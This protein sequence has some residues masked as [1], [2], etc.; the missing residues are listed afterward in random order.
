MAST[1]SE[2]RSGVTGVFNLMLA[3][4]ASGL[5]VLIFYIFDRNFMSPLAVSI[6]WIALP[7]LLI[8]LSI[9]VNIINQSI[10]C[11]GKTDLLSH[12]KISWVTLAIVYSVLFL[13][14]VSYVRAP[15]TSLFAGFFPQN[16][17][18]SVVGLEARLPIVRGI[19]IGYYMLFGI[20]L[21]QII[22]SGYGTICK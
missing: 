8:I 13:T 4:L 1:E 19:A 3:L 6:L 10:Q 2:K 9:T 21:S 16:F 7:I 5:V 15:V 12:I 22:T 20:L 17:A 18:S 14:T 11:D